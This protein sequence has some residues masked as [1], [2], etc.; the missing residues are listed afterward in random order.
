M[1]YEIVEIVQTALILGIFFV[2][3]GRK[4]MPKTP[5]K[6]NGSYIL[7]TSTLIDGRVVR[8]AK[9]GIMSGQLIVPRYVLE[10]L[11]LLADKGDTL[12]RERAR[13]GLVAAD[14]LREQ[15]GKAYQ[16][17]DYAFGK[18]G[19]DDLLLRD[20]KKSQLVLVTLD[21]NLMTR[22][23]AE[24]I[25]VADINKLVQALRPVALP[26][27]KVEITIVQKGDGRGQG[28]GYL[29]DGT[30]V[31]VDHAAR[32]K[33]KK[34]EVAIDRTHQTAS[35]KMMFGHLVVQQK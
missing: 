31:V 25:V 33:N 34:I 32:M 7:D 17:V 8:I 23:K 3:I 15:M 29:D 35:G 18:E 2:L 27:E 14:L 13:V 20:A 21:F 24:G 19:V 22:A 5:A 16:M 26:G 10:E 12:K 4:A 30:M 9:S 28:V 6:V 11:Q 1:R